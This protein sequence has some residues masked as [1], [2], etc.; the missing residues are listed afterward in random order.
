MTMLTL[1]S[2]P[3]VLQW[4]NTPVN[5]NVG[6]ASC[7]SITAGAKTDWFVEPSGS[8]WVSTNAPTALFTPPDE[9][10]LLS[11]KVTVHFASTFDAGVL[12][13]YERED[14]WSK[15]CF[16]YSP[17]NQPMIVSVVTRGLSDDCNSTVIDGNTI[18]LRVA[19]MG[20]A[21]GFHYSL[22]GTYWNMVRY[23]T[24]GNVENLRVGFEAQSP[25]GEGCNVVFSEIAYRPDHLK[26]MRT[27]E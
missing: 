11:A 24:L 8:T 4:K 19:R 18:Y 17:Q 13:L 25:T 2:L 9:H 5:W 20:G 10:F 14:L 12:L 1:P 22:D 3:G 26:D 7:L 21:F 27:G 6:P 15:L 23:F 16:E